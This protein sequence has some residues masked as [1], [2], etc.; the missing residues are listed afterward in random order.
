MRAGVTAGGTSTKIDFGATSAEFL[1][2]ATG[3]TFDVLP[4]PRLTISASLGLSLFGHVDY[5]DRRYDL[6]PGPV[7]GIAVS[8]RLL[9]GR[10]PFVH[11]S[12]ACSLASSKTR[13]P[14][15]SEATFA[16]RDYRFGLA[17][18]YAIGKLAAPFAV[19]RYFGA[20]TNWADVA[21]H[22]A[23]HYRYQVGL[24]SAFGLS[25]HFDALAEVT[26]LGER[27]A[28]VGVGYTF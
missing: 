1:Q 14:E 9:G 6:K 3:A 13:A 23:D 7:G 16:S 18:G 26:I 24:G 25:E 15:G 21:G 8:Y 27:R 22:G 5:L 28:T 4:L 20:G 17:V 10:L 2:G 11:L 12:L 19:A